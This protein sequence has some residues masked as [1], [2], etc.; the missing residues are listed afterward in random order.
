MPLHANAID[1]FHGLQALIGPDTAYFLGRVGL[2]SIDVQGW[3]GGTSS[4]AY[5]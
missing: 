4:S 3:D 1:A 5:C 2:F